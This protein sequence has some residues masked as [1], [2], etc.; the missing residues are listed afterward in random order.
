MEEVYAVIDLKSFYASCECAARGLD[1]FSTPLVVAD[2]SRSANSIVM[3]TTPLPKGELW[4][5]QRLPNRG[6]A[7]DPRHDL[8]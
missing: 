2:K 7:G 8:R 4:G 3:S 1:I 5:P 6:F